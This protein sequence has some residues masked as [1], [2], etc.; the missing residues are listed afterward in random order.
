MGPRIG[1]G[2][3]Q[4]GDFFFYVHMTVH[5]NKF[6]Y[7]KTNQMDQFPKFTSAWNSTCFG[8][9]PLPIIRSLFTAHS[10]LAYVIQ[11][12]PARSVQWINSWWWAQE[13]PE[14][15]RVSLR[16]KFGKL[17]HLV[18]FN[19]KKLLTYFLT[20]WSRVLLEKLTGPQL[21]KK[22]PHFME[23][24]VSLPHSQVPTTCPYSQPARS[25]PHP[26]IQLSEDPS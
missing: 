12:S 24:E 19:I 7:N 9:V 15:Y 14:T 22:F 3:F 26:H 13:L 20:P 18:C 5:R 17:V 2:A 21:V 11:L 23:P 8:A 4:G 1:L 6:L 10:A 16:S 25:I